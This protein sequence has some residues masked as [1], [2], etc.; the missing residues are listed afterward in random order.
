MIVLMQ[1]PPV[2]AMLCGLAVV[3]V[4]VIIVVIVVFAVGVVVVA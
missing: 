1:A 4:D 3:V 2:T